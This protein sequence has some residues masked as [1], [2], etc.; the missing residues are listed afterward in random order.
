MGYSLRVNHKKV[1][2]VS[3]E[4]R[5]EQFHYIAELQETFARRG[6]P[7]VSVDSKKRELVGNFK[8]AGAAYSREPALVNDHDF[9]SIAQAISSLDVPK[10]RA[11]FSRSFGLGVHWPR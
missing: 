2:G 1:S 6:D 3:P 7:I 5:D 9:R 11:I 4:T 8:N 10:A